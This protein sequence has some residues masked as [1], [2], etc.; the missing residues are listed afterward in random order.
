MHDRRM[1]AMK[2]GVG[3]DPAVRV[4]TNE[5]MGASRPTV[6]VTRSPAEANA[7]LNDSVNHTRSRTLL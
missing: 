1:P 7:V 3:I 4:V 5:E 2:D 6:G